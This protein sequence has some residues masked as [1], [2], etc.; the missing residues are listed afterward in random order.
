MLA[1][2]AARFA[3]FDGLRAI[4]AFAVVVHHASLP[5]AT[6][7]TGHFNHQFTQLDTGVSIFFLISG[8]LLYRPF[9]RRILR[10]DP[11]PPVG[12]YLLRRAA[13]IFPAY[14]LAL[15]VI[16]LIGHFTHGRVLGF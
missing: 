11:E 8:F 6:M 4:A 1:R 15:T 9:L 12:P 16:I 14:W 2:G 5:S 7:V 13:R 10:E 3:G